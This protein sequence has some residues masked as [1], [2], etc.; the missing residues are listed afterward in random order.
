MRF[1][2]E[3]VRRVRE[4]VGDDL[5]V[6]YRMSLLDLVHDGQTWDETVVLAKEIEAAGASIINTGIGWH[7]ARVPTIVTQV[8]RGAWSW[9]TEAAAAGGR[10]SRSARPTGSTPP[11][12]PRSSS[13]TATPTWSRWPAVP[14]RP[15]LRAQGRRGPRRRDQHLHRLQ[16]GLPRPHLRR[17][18]APPA[19]STRA[20]ATRPSSSCCRSRAPARRRSRS[21]AAAR[22]GWPPRCPPPSAGTPSTLFEAG[23]ELGGQFRLAM[24][25]PGKEEFAETLRYYRRRFEV[26]GVDVRL[27]TRADADDLAAYDEVVVATGVVPR[28]PSLPGVDHPKVV[29]YADVL[30][31]RVV[32]G[33]PGRGR[34]RRRHR[35]RR[36]GVP[37]PRPRRRP[38]RTGWP[39]GASPTRPCT[40]AA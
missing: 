35:L 20:P 17:T 29:S 23:P 18:S 22:P 25:I 37:D 2:V 4:A 13:P 31:G 12:S 14:G 1:P 16:P 38:S 21:S 15:G 40:A 6:M 39:T 9:T 30:D 19:W 10:R 28:I 7:E 11:S 8:P 3:I 34:R 24:H 5:I 26:L 32:P 33:P 27:G 36:R